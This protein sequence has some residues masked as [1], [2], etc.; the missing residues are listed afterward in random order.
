MKNIVYYYN[1]IEGE[2]ELHENN[3]VTDLI[4][5]AVMER[6]GEN[7]KIIDVRVHIAASALRPLD[8]IKVYLEGPIEI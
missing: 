3:E 7:W 8:L 2:E 1:S 6:A 4:Q 5:G